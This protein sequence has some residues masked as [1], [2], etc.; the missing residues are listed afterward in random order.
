MSDYH[1][2]ITTSTFGLYSSEPYEILERS[3]C[4]V[5]RRVGNPR[6]TEAQMIDLV[7]DADALVV[8]TEPVTEAVLD[9]APRL[10]I[11]ARCG[12]GYDTVSVQAARQRGIVVT[13]TPGANNEAVADMAMGLILAL[14]RQILQEDAS[15]RAGEWR[16][17]P[18]VD[19]WRKTLGVIGLGGTGKSLLK[20]AVGFEMRLLAHDVA[21]DAAFVSKHGVRLLPLDELLREADFVSVHVPLSAQTRGLIGQ[22]ELRLMKSTAFLVNTARGGIVDEGALA[23][24][25]REGIIAGAGVDVFEHEPPGASPLLS[26]R[27]AVLT[28]HVAGRTPQ[29][30][31]ASGVMA[32]TEVTRT[33]RGLPPL[34]PVPDEPSRS[35]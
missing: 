29:S 31:T 4:R 20:R 22:R 28:P 27:N 12:T 1:V 7:H 3:R 6:W 2:V 33:M 19:V 21:P 25:L 11:V 24:A 34:H 8:G 35:A 26:L 17:M 5:S 9:A 23:E 13:Y 14:A 32:S 10:R 15:V 16:R 30:I 18:A